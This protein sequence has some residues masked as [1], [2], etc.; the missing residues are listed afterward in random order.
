MHS[1]Y[2]NFAENLL[3]FRLQELGRKSV[4]IPPTGTRQKMCQHSA[5]R[6]SAEICR[7]SAYRNSAENLPAQ[8]PGRK[9]AGIPPTGTRQNIC[10]QGQPPPASRAQPRAP[11][12]PA[13]IFLQEIGRKSASIPPTGSRQKICQHSA[14]RNSELQNPTLRYNCNS[15]Y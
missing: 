1:A 10:F 9:I 8:K 2:R 14:Y 7:H 11:S 5:Y 13:S 3:A 6:N 12:V 4:S 15:T